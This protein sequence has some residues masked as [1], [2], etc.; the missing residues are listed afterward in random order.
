MQVVCDETNI[1]GGEQWIIS[2]K[3]TISGSCQ[4]WLHTTQDFAVG[5]KGEKNDIGKKM[6]VV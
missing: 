1:K 6:A 5:E 3:W 2:V 4:R